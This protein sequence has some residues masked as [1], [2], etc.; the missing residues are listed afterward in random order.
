MLQ[1]LAE[2]E[3]PGPAQLTVG[4]VSGLGWLRPYVLVAK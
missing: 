4:D 1:E 2:A 3:P